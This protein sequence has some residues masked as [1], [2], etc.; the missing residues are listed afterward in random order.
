M[1]TP[2]T[3]RIHSAQASATRALLPFPEGWYFV[4]SRDQLRN[5]K[6]VHK[7]WLGEEIVVWSDDR[8]RVCMAEAYCPHLG[9][10]LAPEAGAKICA[11]RLVCPFHGFQYDTTGQCVA[12]PYAP[13]PRSARLKLYETRDYA[14][15]IFGWWGLGGRPAQ[16]HLPEAP[17]TDSGWSDIRH[18]TLRF[19][20]HPQ[21]TTENAVDL[22]HLRYVHGYEN[23]HRT[24]RLKTDGAYLLS[25]FD[26]MGTYRVAGLMGV[27]FDISSV[28]HVYGLGF[29]QVEFEERNIGYRARLWVLSTP[30][31]GTSLDLTLATHVGNLERPKRAIVGLRFLPLPARLKL[32]NRFAL[33]KATRYVEEDVL[34]WSR[35]R[36]VARPLLN[37]ADGEIV[38]YRRHCEQF[39][40]DRSRRDDRMLVSQQAMAKD[41]R[42]S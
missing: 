38:A 16:W 29:S 6:L 18:T 8:G 20:G 40:A 13:P 31:D 17:Q 5:G 21:E 25:C 32:I 42:R 19:P 15:M 11:G 7:T 9:S 35:K 24:A 28:T 33:Q 37:R 26:F 3:M 22:A 2:G 23:V 27:S 36:Y 4:A 12:T 34:I 14:G 1:Q 41:P 30:V 10:S 39:Y